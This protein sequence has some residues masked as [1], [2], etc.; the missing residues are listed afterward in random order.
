MSTEEGVTGGA[1]D[2]LEV[3]KKKKKKKKKELKLR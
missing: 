2:K 1:G 3:K